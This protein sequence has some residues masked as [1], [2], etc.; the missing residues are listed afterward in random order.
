VLALF[1]GA[2]LL[3]IPVTLLSRHLGQPWL[4]AMIFG[5]LAMAAIAAYFLLLSSVESLIMSHRDLMAE[6][7]CRT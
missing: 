6:E 2:I 5:P 4:G 1:F 7:L 3:Q